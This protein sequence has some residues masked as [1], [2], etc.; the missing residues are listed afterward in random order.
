MMNNDRGRGASGPKKAGPAPGPYY[1]VS[2]GQLPPPSAPLVMPDR[3][4]DP[5]VKRFQ[6]SDKPSMQQNPTKWTT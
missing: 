4:N 1:C 5:V 3:C 6:A 2:P